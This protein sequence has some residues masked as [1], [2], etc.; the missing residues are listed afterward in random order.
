LLAGCIVADQRH[1]AEDPNGWPRSSSVGNGSS[2]GD[3]HTEISNGK[4]AFIRHSD[5]HVMNSDGTGQMRL[6]RTK[7]GVEGAVW[8]PDGKKIAFSVRERHLDIYVIDAASTTETNLTRTKASSEGAPSW[9]PDGKKITYL[10]GSDPSGEI[11]NDIYVMNSDGTGQMRLIRAKDTKNFEVGFQSPVW[12]PDGEKIAFIRTTRVVPD[13]SASSSAVPATGPSGLYVMKPEGTGLRRLSK[14]IPYAQ[15]PLW[16]P[17]GNKIAFSGAGE[18]KCVVNVGG[19]ELRELMPNVRNHI[20]SYSWSPNG[21]KIAFA[22]VHYRGE[23]DIYVIDADGTGQ[24]NLTS[25]K[26]VIED[27]PSWS[28]DGKQI[29]FTRADA[30]DVYVAQDVYL[31]NADGTGRSRLAT[32]ASSPPF[33]PRDR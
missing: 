30:G 10:K 12:S 6:T 9:S 14:G 7:A 32:G 31:M 11:Y 8:S 20:S 21:K 25:T 5:I 33:T 4:I 24:T 19:T 13:K 22:A 2:G 27:E 16:S 1:T 18:K 28:P 26:T 15:S 17:E 23:L 3:Q 29:A